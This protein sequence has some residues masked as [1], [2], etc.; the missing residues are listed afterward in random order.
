MIDIVLGFISADSVVSSVIKTRCLPHLTPQKPHSLD[1]RV[2]QAIE[3]DGM[4]STWIVGRV[5]LLSDEAVPIITVAV[6]SALPMPFESDPIPTQ[7]EGCRLVLI[8]HW[9]RVIQ[10]VRDIRSP[11]KKKVSYSQNWMVE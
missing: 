7:D 8:P 10:P 1:H 6:E 5:R 2:C 9:H 4:R 3:R 11:L